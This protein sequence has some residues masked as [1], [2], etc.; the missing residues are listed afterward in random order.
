M[1]ELKM[2]VTSGTETFASEAESF[3]S[4]LEKIVEDSMQEDGKVGYTSVVLTNAEYCTSGR[5]MDVM[6][7][8]ALF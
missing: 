2:T 1:N 6:M 4:G 5:K 7:F 3:K 8:T